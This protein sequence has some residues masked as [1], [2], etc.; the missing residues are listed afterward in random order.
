MNVSPRPTDRAIGSFRLLV[1][2]TL[3][4]AVL[5]MVGGVPGTS[6]DRLFSS[7]GGVSSTRG[8]P[9][10]SATATSTP[11]L[12]YSGYPA[13]GTA[14]FDGKATGGVS[15]YKYRW[16]FGDGASSSDPNP[17]HVYAVPGAYLSTLTVTD[18]L[19]AMTTS[20]LAP[21]VGFD[22]APMYEILA[23][24]PLGPS[25]LDVGFQA[26]G[27]PEETTRYRWDFGEGN[28]S[29]ATHPTHKYV[30]PGTYLTRLDLIDSLGVAYTYRI[31]VIALGSE[32]LRV[33][34]S[35][36][37]ERTGTCFPVTYRVEFQSAA[38]G[39]TPPYH[40]FWDFGDS[41][42]SQDPQPSHTYR[43]GFQDFHVQVRVMD[44]EGS[45]ATSSV[46]FTT[47]PP[48]CPTPVGDRSVGGISGVMALEVAGIVTIVLAA[49]VTLLIRKRFAR[50]S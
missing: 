3:G 45:V 2:A 18:L 37:S 47:L 7:E 44:V 41:G 48:P 12:D 25:P 32:P 31:T 38:G 46:V 4:L 24:P 8:N 6:T 33:L 5:L 21:V 40:Y 36:P 35:Y 10:F 16:D 30:R 34:A 28:M 11:I 22:N 14:S 50:A 26:F 29:T 9:A 27:A 23:T 20:T 49:V 42:T 1:I 43:A 13:S 39:G 15:P 19:G 17:V